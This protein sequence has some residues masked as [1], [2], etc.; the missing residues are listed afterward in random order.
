MTYLAHLCIYKTFFFII[1][2]FD[3]KSADVYVWAYMYQGKNS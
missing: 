3:S 2:I 1:I